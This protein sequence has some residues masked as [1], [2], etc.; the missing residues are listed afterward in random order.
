MRRF[1]KA[2]WQG[3]QNGGAPGP[4]EETAAPQL[5]GG[6]SPSRL[7][8][9]PTGGGSRES[10]SAFER[11]MKAEAMAPVARP[12]NRF[13]KVYWEESEYARDARVYR[14]DGAGNL[15]KL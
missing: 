10:P 6:G 14:Q 4:T 1:E 11:K 15:N 5:R 13:D 7:R 3:G 8:G 12:K 2:Y 9:E